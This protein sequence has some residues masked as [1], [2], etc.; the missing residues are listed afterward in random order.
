MRIGIGYDVH[1][2]EKGRRLVLGGINIPFEKG[3]VGWSDADVTIHA[4]IDALLGA[5]ALG[6]IGTHFPSEDPQYK[7]ISSLILLDKTA[8][9]LKQNNWRINN[10]DVT[11]IAQ[12]PKL[13]PFVGQMKRQ[14]AQTLAIRE[15]QI[16]IKAKTA[17]E[18]G[19]VGKGEGIVT[20]AAT[21]IEAIE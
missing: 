12:E 10:V 6:D 4:I 8:I 13:A 17:D 3:L 15:D 2:L 7:D 16:G 9:L 14:I 19:F 5:A 1:K 21:L 11:I 20:H 18:L